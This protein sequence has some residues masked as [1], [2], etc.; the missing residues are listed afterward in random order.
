M[1]N[2]KATQRNAPNKKKGAQRQNN[3][4]KKTS[5][6]RLE[7]ARQQN[8]GIGRQLGA[9]VAYSSSSR[10]N[11][12]SIR[13]SRES[14]R[15]VHRELLCSIV[16]SADYAV[17]KRF[18]LN[19]GI[20]E[21]FPWLATMAPSWEQYKFHSLK[22]IYLTRTG[23]STPGSMMLAPDYDA[24][25]AAPIGELV[26][27]SY[28]GVVED[29]PWKNITCSLPSK[30]LNSSNGFRYV[31]SE[32]LAPNL[33]IKTYDSG[34]MNVITIDGTAV[35][36]GKLWVEYDVEFKIPQLNPNG[37]PAV[38][39]AFVRSEGSDITQNQALRSPNIEQT[40][41]TIVKDVVLNGTSQRVNFG[42]KGFHGILNYQAASVVDNLF[43]GNSLNLTPSAG[44]GINLTEGLYSNNF[45]GPS[46]NG[47]DF[48]YKS[49]VNIL[50]NG[51]LD[52]RFANVVN[53]GASGQLTLTPCGL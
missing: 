18:M 8:S 37:G 49:L 35:N 29:A 43:T 1:S 15:V 5:R 44:S 28:K 27:S 24:A 31:R 4:S 36:W 52:L 22:F 46:F 23:T 33:D 2:Y 53:P 26:A 21:S 38:P 40:L 16:G 11:G 20:N 14:C 47:R 9:A 45:F 30:D 32:T 48:L 25:D 39:T 41:Q 50:P 12:P 7:G 17:F 3:S 19:P 51:S 10:T 6:V 13:A 42:D 34:V